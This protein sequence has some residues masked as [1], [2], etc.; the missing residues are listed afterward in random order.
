MNIHYKKVL[1][2][3]A[4]FTLLALFLI[5]FSVKAQEPATPPAWDFLNL[6]SQPS[7]Y[8]NI[9]LGKQHENFMDGQAYVGTITN[10]SLNKVHVTGT[11]VAYLTCGNQVSS[12]FDVTLNPGEVAGGGT[13]ALFNADGLGGH[14]M[15]TDCQ[16]NKI[17]P[18]PTNNPTFWYYDRI[19]DV[20]ITNLQVTIIKNDT[21]PVITS[22]NNTVNNNVSSNPTN[23]SNSNNNTANNNSTTITSQKQAQM[24]QFTNNVSNQ[25]QGGQPESTAQAASELGSSLGSLIAS[26]SSSNSNEKAEIEQIASRRQASN[27]YYEIQNKDSNNPDVL[28]NLGM[29]YF[30]GGDNANSYY[31]YKK[32]AE[33]GNVKAMK[34]LALIFNLGFCGFKPHSIDSEKYWLAQAASKGNDIF[35]YYLL[36]WYA[37]SNN[38]DCQ[39]NNNALLFFYKVESLC[40]QNMPN[41]TKETEP[42]IE[43]QASDNY[44]DYGAYCL[45]EK[46]IADIFSLCCEQNKTAKESLTDAIAR[47]NKSLLLGDVHYAFLKFFYKKEI[48]KAIATDEKKL[49]ELGN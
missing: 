18:D 46:A 7:V 39:Q 1:F 43:G 28:Y 27:N 20:G 23:N 5:N 11:I 37:I 10:I 12:Q 29:L 17:Y 25:M 49:K 48:K 6:T 15:N 24:Q 9:L 3:I 13:P 19:K 26:I 16:G 32:A 41:L 42:P 22:D 4:A 30:N 38:G 31:Y 21:A 44:N 45:T 40:S 36:G 8:I 34:E 35:S 33:L 2:R 47:Y 14:A